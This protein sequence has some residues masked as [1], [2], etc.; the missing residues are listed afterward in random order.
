MRKS[1]LDKFGYA[2]DRSEEIKDTV[3]QCTR[4]FYCFTRLKSCRAD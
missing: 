4:K 1:Y 3:R 2:F